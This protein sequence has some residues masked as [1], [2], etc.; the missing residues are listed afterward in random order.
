VKKLNP[1]W[2]R[3]M[4][5]AE[6]AAK[7]TGTKMDYE[8]IAG[9]FNILP[10]EIISQVINANLNRIGGIQYSPYE[11][12]FAEKIYS[13]FESPEA[14]LGLEK[15]IQPLQYRV[16]NISTDV[17]DVSWIA[18]SGWLSTATFV[19]GTFLHSWQAV[20]AGGMSIGS[21]GMILAAKTMAMTACDFYTKPNLVNHAKK[22]FEAK[23]GQDFVYKA[24]VGDRKP[25]LDYKKK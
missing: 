25:P 3:V 21:K 8:I 18:P 24:L 4:N 6:G 14:E 16:R 17:G 2:E 12:E 20:A 22:E 13:T 23:R 15:E 10:N 7:G 1:I 9:A 19:P 5:A 11:Q